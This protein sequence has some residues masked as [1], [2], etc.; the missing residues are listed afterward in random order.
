MA[1]FKPQDFDIQKDFVAEPL[2]PNGWYRGS[3]TNVKLNLDKHNLAW[4]ITFNGNENMFFS[5]GKTPVDGAKLYF[6]NWLP[7]KPGDEVT[8][9]DSG[10]QTKR[11]SKINM[12][13][14]FAN[15]IGLVEE[16]RDMTAIATTVQEK[17]LLSMDIIAK[18]TENEYNG[19]ISNQVDQLVRP[20]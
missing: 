7:T 18:V 10:K 9:S 8:M 19:E 15:K 11:Q 3:V 2:I 14:K 17:K 12:L 5:D 4:E 1:E 20:S 6:R 13:S 16:M